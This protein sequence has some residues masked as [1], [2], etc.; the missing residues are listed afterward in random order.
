MP[1]STWINSSYKRKNLTFSLGMTPYPETSKY[2]FYIIF[3][4]FQIW[5]APLEQH[6]V[7]KKSKN[8]FFYVFLFISK[9]FIRF[10]GSG[11]GEVHWCKPLIYPSLLALTNNCFVLS[12]NGLTDTVVGGCTEK[13]AKRTLFFFLISC[14][15]TFT[16]VNPVSIEICSFREAKKST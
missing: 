12:F 5:L 11:E 2:D 7:H 3:L 14:T 16:L 10:V 13:A 8:L 1:C 6:N 4:C 15:F 9:S